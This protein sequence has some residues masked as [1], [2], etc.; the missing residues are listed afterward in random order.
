VNRPGGAA[1]PQGPV[2]L[3]RDVG[4]GARNIALAGAILVMMAGVFSVAQ[5]WIQHTREGIAGYKAWVVA[6]PPCAPPPAAVLA[7]PAS[8]QL[9][10]TTFGVAK[11]A[12]QHGATNCNDVATNGGWG[13]DL[14][15]V[16]QFD[17][18]GLVEVSTRR[19]VYRFWPG[20]LSPAT[21][22]VEND[23]ATCVVGASQGFDDRLVYDSP[24][25]R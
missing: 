13:F 3:S 9:Q 6:G 23:V 8:R 21:V 24:T 25:P 10:V 19:G 16:C 18:P 5:D 22:S 12:R 15:Q 4:G 7:D 2:D 11:F 20:H 1:A 14:F 17:H